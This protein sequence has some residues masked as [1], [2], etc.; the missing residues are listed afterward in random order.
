MQ[1]PTLRIEQQ[2]PR[3]IQGLIVWFPIAK[4]LWS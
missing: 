4:F 2:P 1:K 3:I